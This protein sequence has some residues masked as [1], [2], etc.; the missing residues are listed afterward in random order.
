MNTDF[1]RLAGEDRIARAA[2]AVRIGQLRPAIVLYHEHHPFGDDIGKM[3]SSDLARKPDLLLVMGTSLK[4]D[5]VRKLVKEFARVVH[6]RPSSG[7]ALNTIAGGHVIFVN[8]TRADS[9]C[10]KYIDFFVQGETDDW[11][12]RTLTGA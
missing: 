8:K 2:R 1:L 7:S 12:Q 10:M 4:V 11:V 9:D 3:V 5:G 6:E